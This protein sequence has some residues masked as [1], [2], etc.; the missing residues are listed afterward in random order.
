LSR[1]PPPT[2]ILAAIHV[3]L[4]RLILKADADAEQIADYASLTLLDEFTW[5]SVVADYLW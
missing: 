4:M 1:P 5:E 3:S 2:P